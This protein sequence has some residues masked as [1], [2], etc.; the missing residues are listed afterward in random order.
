VLSKAPRPLVSIKDIARS[1]KVSHSTVS[2]ALRH[3]PLVNPKTAALIRRIAAK[4]GYVASAVARSLVTRATKTVGVV[5]TTISDPF[6]AEVVSGI[7]EA[8]DQHGYS[9]ILA[10][11][12]AQAERE[13]RAVRGF[14]ERRVDG[15]LVTASRVGAMYG[16]LLES[17]RLPIVL[18]NNQ[19]PGEF[20]HT[21]MI[22]NVPASRGAV[23]HLIALGHR[24]IAY[25][26]DRLGFQSD[27]ERLE[28]Y[29]EALHKGG[30]AELADLVC[31]GDGKAEE[32]ERRTH[33]LL[34][35]AQ[36]PTAIFCYNDMSAI[37]A[38]RAAHSRRLDVPRDLSL[39]GFDDLFI[40]SYTTPPLTTVR[41]PKHEMGKKAMEILLAILSGGT[42][43][44]RFTMKGELIVRGSTAPPPATRKTKQN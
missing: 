7:E 40:A 38:L 8:A 37:G 19:Y 43:E 44:S 23:G 24:R 39:I 2:R 33:T 25:I 12:H 26:G 42:A 6:I 35:L 17:M 15:I 21:V 1:A 3:S 9:V 10:N 14:G 4:S 11:S 28:G 41:Q 34:D 27:A 22:D 36:P 30:I 16:S 31:H 13:M 18:I 20:A 29:R 32:A 5:V